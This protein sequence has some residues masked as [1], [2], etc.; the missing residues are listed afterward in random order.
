MA[1]CV[2]V[3]LTARPA[4]AADAP[5]WLQAAA[6]LAPL[7]AEAGADLVVLHDEVQ[8]TVLADNRLVSK[9]RYAMRVQ[10]EDGISQ[11]RVYEVYTTDGGSIRTMRGWQIRDGRSAEIDRRDIADVALADND[12]YNEARV[13][14]LS[15]TGLARGVVFG[16]E[17]ESVERLAYPQLQW[18][19]Q[20]AWPVRRAR[21]SLVLPAGWTAS[22]VVLNH[23][24]VDASRAGTTLTWDFADLPPLTREVA[25]PPLTTR[26]ARLGVTFG[27]ESV[28]TADSMAEWTAVSRWLAELQDPQARPSPALVERARALTAGATT[29]LEKIRAIA[30]YVQ[31]V[32][33]ISIQTGLGRGGGYK[34]RLAADVFTK[35][36]GD[37][38]D[39]ANL[40]RAMLDSVGIQSR[41]VAIYSGD[42]DYVQEVWPSPQQFNHCIIAIVVAG[43]V[44][45]PAIVEHPVTGRLLFFDPTDEYTPVGS[46]PL[47]EQGSLAL[48]AMPEGAPLL[49]MAGVQPVANVVTRQV[50]AVLA[51]TGALTATVRVSSTGGFASDERRRYRSLTREQFI[52]ALER[53]AR[54]Q[55]SR[56]RI[57]EAAVSDFATTQNRFD[58]RM[59]LDAPDYAQT[60]AG[61]L[62]LL[63]APATLSDTLPA[64][65]GSRRVSPIR[66]LPIER[67]DQF[68]VE[69][70]D[71]L[72]VDELPAPR[73]LDTPYGRLSV[74][75]TRD[76]GIVRREFTLQVPGRTYPASE[77]AAVQ[78]FLDAVRDAESTPAILS[79]R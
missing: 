38:K 74:L 11:A 28:L 42:P 70:R 13:R 12:V 50:D 55:V 6:R 26:A 66:L 75:W 54:R 62:L 17:V 32:Q 72:T 33:Y 63:R 78:S 22:A 57:S 14:V 49:R 29:D 77:F 44:S 65:S 67:R 45:A 36:Y 23:P 40:M 34:P 58:L 24:P 64:L 15:P 47:Y 69:I 35:N 79:T 2:G 71:G 48:V 18:A 59:N 21:R 5:D 46:L 19:V 37:C 4:A 20:D 7:E 31:Q 10:T 68:V 76:A 27:A 39:K 16:V 53:S 51:G 25:G 60:L 8:V 61:R 52:E 3:A 73:Q 43:D 9:R 41:L 56:A 30:G 1:L